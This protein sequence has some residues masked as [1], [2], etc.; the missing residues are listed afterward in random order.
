MSTASGTGRSLTPKAPEATTTSAAGGM[1]SFENMYLIAQLRKVACAGKACG[2][3]AYHGYLL[4]VGGGY[5][6]G[7]GALCHG[8]VGGEALGIG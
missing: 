2:A 7:G 6:G 5:L 8:V 1:Q 3:G 4:A